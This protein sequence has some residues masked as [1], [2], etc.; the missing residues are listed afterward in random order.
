MLTISFSRSA[1]ARQVEHTGRGGGVPHAEHT[2]LL[3][4]ERDRVTYHGPVLV[5]P[6]LAD[7]ADR[8]LVALSPEAARALARQLVQVAGPASMSDIVDETEPPT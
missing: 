2:V 1:T 8:C 4:L 3:A 5:Y 7:A 6:P